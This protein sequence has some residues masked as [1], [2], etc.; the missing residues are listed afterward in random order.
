MGDHRLV[1]VLNLPASDIQVH[2]RAASHRLPRQAFS[3]PARGG[4]QIMRIRYVLSGVAALAAFGVLAPVALA[5]PAPSSPA[6]VKQLLISAAKTES[7]AYVQYYVYAAGADHSGQTALAG[8]WRTVG[9]VEHQDHWNH[10]ITLAGLYS[11][12]NN[13]ANLR[14]AITQARQAA[15]ADEGWAARAPRGSAAARELLTVAARETADARLL[16]QALSALQGKGGSVP[17]ATP[18][19]QVQVRVSAAPHY[20][21][22]FYNDLTGDSNSAIETAAWNWA[23]YQYDAKTAVDTRQANL[24]KLLSGLE[25]QEAQNWTE[26]SNVAGYVNGNAR[27]LR[28]SI[29]SEQAA[30]NM[31]AQYAKEAQRAGSTSVASTF[32]SIMGDEE[33]HH[34]TFTA[35]LQ[36]LNRRH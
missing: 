6:S 11:G 35:E 27:N 26:L 36:K 9:R 28:T 21:G 4:S 22:A 30:I 10:E 25:A 8:V 15:T 20:S 18:V 32:R 19:R 24:A 16:V 1:R 13:V 31:Y 33:G 29:A 3:G 14:L 23:E 17:A 7:D 5:A 2:A 12:S 34:Q